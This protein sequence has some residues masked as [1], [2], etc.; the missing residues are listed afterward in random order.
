[1]HL[2]I[3]QST[4]RTEQ[5]TTACID[6]LYNLSK[7][8]TLDGTSY[9]RGSINAAAAYED[10]VTFLNTTWGPDLIVTA[11]DYYIRFADPE[12]ES[13]LKTAFNK[14]EGEGITTQEAANTVANY[15]HNN[16]NIE[17][18]DEFRHFKNGRYSFYSCTNLESIDLGSHNSLPDFHNCNNLKYF[19]GINSDEGVLTIPEEVT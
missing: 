7:S 4:D 2:V 13:V 3:N 11:S 15:F 6:K 8:N 5:V 9:L 17:S 10:A 14:A 19:S 16:T 18:F 1:M 12:V